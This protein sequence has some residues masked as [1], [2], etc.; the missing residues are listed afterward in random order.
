MTTVIEPGA[1]DPVAAHVAAFERVLHGPARARRSMIDEIRDGLH[2]AEAAYRSRGLDRQ[3]AGLQAVRDFGAVREVA[4][5]IQEELTARQA[6]WAALLLAAAFPALVEGWDLLWVVTGDWKPAPTPPVVLLLAGTQD[7]VSYG[8]AVAALVLLAATFRR[9]VPPR[10]ITATVGLMGA[11]GAV[12]CLCMSTAMWVAN[13]PAAAS[14]VATHPLGLP[15]IAGTFVLLGAVF[16]SA[17]RSLRVARHC[18]S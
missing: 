15:V 6:R 14:I 4:P 11:L 8:I 17:A 2:D 16:R 12:A 18:P 3:R 13:A 10:W 7:T 9:M 5:L 1:V